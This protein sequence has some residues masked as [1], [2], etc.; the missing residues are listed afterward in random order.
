MGEYAELAL[1]QEQNHFYRDLGFDREQMDFR[2]FRYENADR[3][4]QMNG[5]IIAIKDMS[6]KHLANSI[7]MLERSDHDYSDCPAYHNLIEE[8]M[9]RALSKGE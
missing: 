1:E 9:I 8:C 5:D 3:W 4:L 2:A 7:A 6:D